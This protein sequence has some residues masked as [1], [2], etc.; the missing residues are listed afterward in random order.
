MNPFFKLD[1]RIRKSIILETET[2]MYRYKENDGEEA[3][4]FKNYF[5]HTDYRWDF[6]A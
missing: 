5:F 2:G 6:Q 3:A 1:Y 4:T